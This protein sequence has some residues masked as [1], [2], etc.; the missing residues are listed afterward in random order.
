M[1]MSLPPRSDRPVIKS[2]IR[3][4]N[5]QNTNREIAQRL[6]LKKK[7]KT[8]N[9]LVTIVS[10][11]RSY[12]EAPSDSELDSPEGLRSELN[13]VQNELLLLTPSRLDVMNENEN[14]EE[15][16]DLLDSVARQT[17]VM[18]EQIVSQLAEVRN[19]EVQL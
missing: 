14:F 16:Q 13:N 8:L 3:E 9:S 17:G 2:E 1:C 19:M 6:I 12:Q 10:T 5:L 7:K 11:C 18:Y 15:A 4:T